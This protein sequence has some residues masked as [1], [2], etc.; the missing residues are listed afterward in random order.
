MRFTLIDRI[1][2]LEPG[3]RIVAVKNLTLAEEYLA[4]HFPGFPVMPGVLMLEAM[5]QAGAWLV[6]VTDDF[7]QSMVVLKDARRI[8]YGQLVDPGRQLT[9]EVEIEGRQEHL[10][11]LKGK[12][13]LGDK[14]AVSGRLVLEHYNLGDRDAALAGTDRRVIGRLKE[15]YGVLSAVEQA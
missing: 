11:E 9:I 10:T 14:T 2:S 1:T 15:L 13:T 7:R 12:G 8:K 4:D 5:V 3:R 6:R